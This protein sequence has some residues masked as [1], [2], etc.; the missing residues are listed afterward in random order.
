MVK[1]QICGRELSSEPGLVQHH[2]AKHPDE[3]LPQ[4]ISNETEQ[5]EK[6]ERGPK[7]GGGIRRNLQ[8]R[9]R[10]RRTIIFGVA[11]VLAVAG[12]LGGYGLYNT[13]AHP[14]GPYGSFPLPCASA[15]PLHVHPYLRI[16]IDGNNITI[17]ASIGIN[18]GC[19][20]PLHTHDA[21]GIIHVEAPDTSTQ[22]TLGQFFEIWKAS[23]GSVSINGTNHPIV[24]NSMDI[25]G[26]KADQGHQVVLL[27]DG[28]P[29][30]TWGD[31]ILNQ[32][33]Y[34]SAA[35]TGPPCSPTAIGEPSFG[36][37]SYPY[38]TG[39]TIVIE[40]QAK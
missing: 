1:C 32:L 15:T 11:L 24:F 21:S 19:L 37:Q 7:K 40:Y 23:D 3:P 16:V 33:D 22:Y 18:G 17:P 34:C 6:E 36:S 10:R 31:L 12:G 8:L 9:R 26:F 39:H 2:N 30:T 28:K 20:E 14:G 13:V 4:L 25:L 38:G 29:S 5:A 27:V 35:T